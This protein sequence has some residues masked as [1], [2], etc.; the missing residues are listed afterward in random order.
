MHIFRE[1]EPLRAYLTRQ[2]LKGKNVGLVPTMGA[3]HQGHL[4]LIRQAKTENDIVVCSVF[5]NPVQFNNPN[6]LEKYPRDLEADLMLLEDNQC[7]VV[8]AP[9][10]LEMYPTKN[11]IRIGAGTLENI[12][13]GEFRPGHFAGVSLVVAKLFNIV[14]P[15][16]AYFGLKDYQ[17]FRV[18]AQMVNDLNFNI[19]VVPVAI[20]REGDGLAMSSRNKRLNSDEHKRA[21]T[22]YKCLVHVR[23][24]LL[25]GQSFLDLKKDVERMCV[26]NSIRLEY[27]VL[28]GKESLQ[29]AES[30][31][32]KEGQILLIAAYVG[33]IRLIDN[34]FVS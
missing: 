24:G 26:E 28:A 16:R 23:S 6:D 9:E 14:Q 17:Q 18:I 4:N 7:D 3:L 12:L 32:R 33:E 13:E 27:M 20:A 1:I 21:N 22:L 30:I 5:V 34:L 31:I 10:A 2:F 19:K 15:Q 25:L 11:E 8:F 29:P